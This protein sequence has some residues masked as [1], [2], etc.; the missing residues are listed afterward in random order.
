MVNSK[1]E[2]VFPRDGGWTVRHEGSKKI[3]R[4]FGIKKDAVEYAG[5]IA[6]D[7]GGSVITHKYNGQFKEFKNGNE[8]HVRT[9]KIAPVIT[10]TAE[11]RSPPMGIVNLT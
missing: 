6:S 1:N 2:H 11:I 8:I 3:S 9:H 10:G 7:E 5:I 4:L